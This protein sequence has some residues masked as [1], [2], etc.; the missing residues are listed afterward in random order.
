MGKI[1]DELEEKDIVYFEAKSDTL[2]FTAF[3]WLEDVFGDEFDDLDSLDE[4][5]AFTKRC[6]G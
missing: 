4:V 5:G 2:G 3:F 1:K 6:H